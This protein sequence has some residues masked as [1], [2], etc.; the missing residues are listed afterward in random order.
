MLRIL[1]ARLV[2]A[3]VQLGNL[4]EGQQVLPRRATSP[5]LI[6][7]VATFAQCQPV[8]Q[9]QLFG[10]GEGVDI[11]RAKPIS[12]RLPVDGEV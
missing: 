4:P 7:R 2:R 3:D 9:G 1:P 5:F 10:A 8:P 11:G 6:D 12:R